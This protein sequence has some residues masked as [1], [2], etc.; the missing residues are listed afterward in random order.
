MDKMF[1]QSPFTYISE[2]KQKLVF[3]ILPPVYI[4]KVP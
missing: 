1:M 3:Y 4:Y 2:W